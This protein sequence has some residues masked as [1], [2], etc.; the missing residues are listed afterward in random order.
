MAKI[1]KLI[2]RVLTFSFVISAILLLIGF[3][4]KEGSITQNVIGGLGFYGSIITINLCVL[5]MITLII[6]KIVREK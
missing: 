1:Q 4:S 3:V 2:L 6:S 5:H